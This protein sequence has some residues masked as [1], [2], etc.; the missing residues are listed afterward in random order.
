MGNISPAKAAEEMNH[1]P[2]VKAN[3]L[4]PCAEIDDVSNLTLLSSVSYAAAAAGC[5]CFAGS[6]E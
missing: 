5:G 2:T 1:P 3:A 6:V 4:N